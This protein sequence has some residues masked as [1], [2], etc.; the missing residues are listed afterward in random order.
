[1]DV[2]VL[3]QGQRTGLAQVLSMDNTT[4]TPPGDVSNQNFMYASLNVN[5]PKM[6]NDVER[7]MRQSNPEEADAF[8][9]GMRAVPTPD[10][11]TINLEKELLDHLTGP[12]R[13]QMGSFGT[14]ADA[15]RMLMSLGHKNQ[16]ALTTFLSQYGS[17]MMVMPQRELR[18]VQ[19]F[20]SPML[21]GYAV[22]PASDALMIGSIPAIEQAMESAP[23][24][25]LAETDAWRR[26]ARFIPDDAWF[27]MY[28]DE[29]RMFTA[30]L[31]YYEGIQDGT[32]QPSF[33]DPGQQIMQSL[34][35]SL[36]PAMSKEE[37]SKARELLKYQTASAMTFST[38]DEGVLI[39]AVELS[40]TDD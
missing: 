11:N 17:M 15:V 20:G 35:S 28:I 12:L 36:S 24:E 37:L 10:G 1:M 33:M 40:P 9:Q 7:M 21:Q 34:A 19:L 38:T 39:T 25:A 2:L 31:T 6:L 26:M 30:A 3:M 4:S 23:A 27:T 22:A 14:G 32:I 16:G 29:K 13:F 5:V 8:R 18:G